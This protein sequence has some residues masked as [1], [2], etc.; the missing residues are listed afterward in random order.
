MSRQIVE[1]KL[2][3]IIDPQEQRPPQASQR[4]Q[5]FI[6]GGG[7]GILIGGSGAIENTLFQDTVC[8]AVEVSGDTP[9]WI[10][11]GH[12]GQIPED[13]QGITGFLNYRH[14]MGSGGTDFEKIYPTKIR[15][16]VFQTLQQRN[17]P[18]L[19]T[20]YVLCG[21]PEA[22]VT[23][24]T[25]ILPLDLSDPEAEE[26]FYKGVNY[27]LTPDLDCIY[28]EGGSRSSQPVNP[29]IV[30]KTKEYINMCGNHQ[31]LL[32]AGGGINSPEQAGL[33]VSSA[34]YLVVGNYFE[35]NGAGDT[36]QFV[37]ALRIEDG[38]TLDL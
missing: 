12:I 4:I 14:I 24:V 35:K 16:H 23:R 28:I 30:R 29:N 18:S 6:E 38:Y 26:R 19:S 10:F 25:G 15:N 5:E 17:I 27:W 13:S 21:D 7:K 22:S 31:T 37:Q 36:A 32:F 20:L 2:A 9:T 3:I 11:P 1:T 33:F 34:D 8:A